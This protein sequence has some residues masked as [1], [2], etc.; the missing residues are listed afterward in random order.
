MN[1]LTTVSMAAPGPAKTQ[2]DFW[3]K[4]MRDPLVGFLAQGATPVA[5]SRAIAV[6]VVCGV[7]P[8][9]GATTLL[10]LGA[11]LL[12]RLNQPVMQTVNY[13]LSPVQLLLIP[14]FVQAG[15]WILGANATGFSLTAM[16]EFAREGSVGEFLIQFGWAGA[17]ALVAWLVAAPLIYALGLLVVS[18]VINRLAANRVQPEVKS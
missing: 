8:F 6:A 12:L 2:R 7:F 1:Q 18:P 5:L 4:R 3:Q 9:L 11:G 17:Y 16:L 10:T 13:L 14:V 15:A